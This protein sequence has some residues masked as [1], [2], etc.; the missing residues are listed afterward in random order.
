MNNNLYLCIRVMEENV[1]TSVQNARIK[2]VT[3]S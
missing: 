3:T 1:I 2:H